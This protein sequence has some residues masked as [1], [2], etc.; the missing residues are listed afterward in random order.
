MPNSGTLSASALGNVK[1][2]TVEARFRESDVFRHL[3]E[4]VVARAWRP[5]WSR[6]EGFAVHAGVM[7]ADANGIPPWAGDWIAVEIEKLGS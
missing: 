3:F 5:A 7:E 4:G 6:G 1:L 2:F